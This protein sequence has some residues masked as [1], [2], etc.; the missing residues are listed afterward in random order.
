VT[1]G[2]TNGETNLVK[3]LSELCAGI[4][5]ERSSLRMAPYSELD[6]PSKFNHVYLLFHHCWVTSVLYR[7]GCTVMA[8]FHFVSSV[9]LTSADGGAFLPWLVA[10]CYGNS[11]WIWCCV[12]TVA[13][14]I[15]FDDAP[16][17]QHPKIHTYALIRCRV[18]GEPKPE[19]TWRYGGKRIQFE[20]E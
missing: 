7:W 14:D 5:S 17:P 12:V 13:E 4:G 1:S 3:A 19:V 20:G 11:V 8:N 9:C 10:G 18:S 2:W 16:S 6:P 15:T